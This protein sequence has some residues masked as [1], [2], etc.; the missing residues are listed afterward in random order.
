MTSLVRI[1]RNGVYCDSITVAKS[2]DKQH[3]HVLRDID[4]LIESDDALT[5]PDLDVLNFVERTREYRGQK[6]RYFDM[7]ED[8][9]AMLALGFTGNKARYFKRMFIH[10]FRAQ[11]EALAIREANFADSEWAFG[12]S[13][14]KNARKLETD[15]IK[16]FIEYARAQGHEFKGN[17]YATLTNKS[18]RA[19]GLMREISKP[20]RDMIDLI[21]LTKIQSL[22][23]TIASSFMR[24]MAEGD[25]YSAILL[26]VENDIRKQA[27]LVSFDF[28]ALA[29]KTSAKMLKDGS[30]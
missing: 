22:E 24:Y 12:R 25:H 27:E 28:A 30:T 14:G 29:A 10:E 20:A 5:H 8:A 11:K 2:F 7:D 4:S 1:V 15:A 13:R 6:T 16:S 17:P 3:F 21:S 23:L 9:F 19:I 18:Y 26:K